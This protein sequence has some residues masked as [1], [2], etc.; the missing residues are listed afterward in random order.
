MNCLSLTTTPH[1]K[2]IN[3]CTLCVWTWFLAV[4]LQLRDETPKHIGALKGLLMA[5]SPHL[6]PLQFTLHMSIV[7]HPALKYWNCMPRL[8]PSTNY[9][10]Y[11]SN[12]IP[13]RDSKFKY[14][15]PLASTA[16]F[17]LFPFLS[18][19][20]IPSIIATN[21]TT[22]FSL[23]DQC[24]KCQVGGEVPGGQYTC[25]SCMLI[26][27]ACDNPIINN[28][29]RREMYSDT[30]QMKRT[31]AWQVRWSM[32]SVPCLACLTIWC[33][34]NLGVAISCSSVS[35]QYYRGTRTVIHRPLL[36][37]VCWCNLHEGTIVIA[38]LDICEE[39]YI[40]IIAIWIMLFA[41]VNI[42][43]VSPSMEF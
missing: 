31:G 10:K 43:V 33:C 38:N 21:S 7:L 14:T 20:P 23:T 12:S 34:C 39:P 29:A 9:F 30:P 24:H 2:Q 41:V 36:P 27:M 25:I 1:K 11:D 4:I 3:Y 22:G 17:F 13:W 8:Q 6:P 28:W 37:A 16:P 26:S 15:L 19:N 18:Q 35:E 32:L 42:T 5:V 40:Q